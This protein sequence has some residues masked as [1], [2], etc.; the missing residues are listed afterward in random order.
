M[1]TIK[2]DNAAADSAAKIQAAI[3]GLGKTGGRIVLPE[4]DLTLDR[5]IELRSGVE[6]VGQGEGTILR[7]GAGRVYPLTGYHNYGMCDVP[8]QNAEGLEVGMT[9]SVLDSVRHGFYETFARIT[10][11][12]GNWVGLDHGIEADYRDEDEPRLTT[13]YPLIFGHGIRGA[14][15]R[16]LCLDGRINDQDIEMGGCRGAALYLYQSRD[17]EFENVKEWDYRGEGLGFQMCRDI[18]IRNCTFDRNTGNGF[19][20][21]AGSTNALF[22]G[23]TARGNGKSGFFFCVRAN[24]ITVRDCAFE[25]NGDGISIGT[26]DCNNLIESCTLTGN[27]GPGVLI[28]QVPPSCFVHS[29]LVRDCTIGGNAKDRDEGQIEVQGNA[30]DLVFEGNR[31]EAGNGPGISIGGDVRSIF[32]EH[33]EF[34]GCA[35]EIGGA[36]I[37]TTADRPDIECGCD[38][39]DETIFRHLAPVWDDLTPDT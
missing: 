15:V 23:C 18:R 20:P 14:A 1:K 3:D 37:S 27:K 32:C 26:R 36:P 8:L 38:T 24:H 34:Q 11:V 21:G 28:R 5:S 6:L 17:V 10:W 4:M 7:K 22:E 2:L 9:V 25:D 13:A 19:H 33:N 12:D 30:H 35:P 29:V 31:I 16:D 39:G